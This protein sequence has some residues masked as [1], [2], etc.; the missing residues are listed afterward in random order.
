MSPMKIRTQQQT[1][2]TPASSF[3]SQCLIPLR[4]LTVPEAGRH[5]P[6]NTKNNKDYPTKLVFMKKV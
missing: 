4:T 2:H 1:F 5:E 6:A 3:G